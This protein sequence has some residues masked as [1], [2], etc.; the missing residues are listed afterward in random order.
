MKSSTA[1]KSESKPFF[2]KGGEGRGGC[3]SKK[4]LIEEFSF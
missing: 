4:K 1:R 3:G 2:L